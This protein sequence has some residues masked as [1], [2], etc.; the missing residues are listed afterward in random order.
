MQCIAIIPAR[1]HSSRFPGKPLV[2]IHGKPMIWWVV[3]RVSQVVDEV[4]V[5]TDHTEIA[6][7][8]SAFGGNV[9]MTSPEHA[10]GTD[11]CAEAARILADTVDFDVVLNVQG[12][13]PFIRP[14]QLTEL[15]KSFT[16]GVEIATLA[17]RI[18]DPAELEN[19]NKPKVVVSKTG[20]AL[21]FSR[22]VIPYL[23]GI[24]RNAWMENHPFLA[25]VGLYGYRKDILQEITRLPQGIL[26][27]AESLEQLRWLENGFRIRVTET[28]YSSYGIDTPED[29][30]HAMKLF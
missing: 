1:Y 8:V 12:D 6:S 4:W 23:R 29:L 30:A 3:E 15:K 25:H 26:E 7:T 10:S 16:P 11:R 22:S 21:Y 24:D 19:P 2:L 14:E 18:S 13:E 28:E 27:K 9:L 17:R 5:A 20:E